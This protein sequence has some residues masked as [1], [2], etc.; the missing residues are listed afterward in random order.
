MTKAAD[1]LE[2]RLKEEAA[3][4]ILLNRN[5]MFAGFERERRRLR[6]ESIEMVAKSVERTKAKC[7]SDTALFLRRKEEAML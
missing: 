6:E 2:E 7:R 5:E 3:K 4:R 1:E